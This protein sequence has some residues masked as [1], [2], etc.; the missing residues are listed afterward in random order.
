MFA[1]MWPPVSQCGRPGTWHWEPR[2]V[3]TRLPPRGLPVCCFFGPSSLVRSCGL[4]CQHTSSSF[5]TWSVTCP[6][7]TLLVVQ[8]G[9]A[10][11]TSGRCPVPQSYCVSEQLSKLFS[12]HLE[13]LQVGPGF[14]IHVCWPQPWPWC[15]SL[16]L[17]CGEPWHSGPTHRAGGNRLWCHSRQ[18]ELDRHMC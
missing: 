5:S 10:V 7:V 18:Q 14:S 8:T 9:P 1:R 3:K 13:C 6:A 17:S 11:S 12:V 2:S 15:S 4:F 16:G